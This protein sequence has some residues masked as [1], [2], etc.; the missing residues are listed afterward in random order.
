MLKY[1]RIMFTCEEDQGVYKLGAP[2]D[3]L[4]GT[5]TLYGF[6]AG[7]SP[8]KTVL[9]PFEALNFDINMTR[10][11]AD[12][13]EIEITVQKEPGTIDPDRVQISGTVQGGLC[14]LIRRLRLRKS[15]LHQGMIPKS[16]FSASEIRVR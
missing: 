16:G 2:M 4:N 12:S 13:R 6:C 7:F 1:H 5:I 3:P 9:T 14:V 10:P 11:A 8:F 15:A